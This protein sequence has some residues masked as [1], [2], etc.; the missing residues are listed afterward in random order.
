MFRVAAGIVIGAG[1]V[2]CGTPPPTGRQ[3]PEPIEYRPDQ[4][5]DLYE[6]IDTGAAPVVVVAVH[7]CCGDRRD[8]A[9]LS[10]ALVE[11]G[12]VVANADVHPLAHRG[13]W[14]ETYVDVVCAYAWAVEYAEELGDETKVAIVGWGDGALVTAAVALG[15]SSFA[16]MPD[17][18]VEVSPTV[19]PALVV[20]VG[21]HFGW[22]GEPSPSIVTAATVD[23]F[24]GDPVDQPIA[25]THGNPGWWLA[26]DDVRTT[27]SFALV[28]AENDGVTSEFA[29]NLASRA[30]RADTMLI[31][32]AGHAD[33]VQPR[34]TPGANALDAITQALQLG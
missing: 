34:G 5:L 24:G 30:I 11:R 33:L 20:A 29:A 21:G 32:G 26:S 19:G 12:A 6:P 18:C 4:V 28:G 1:L 31:V 17:D 2:A 16:S 27:V 14:P 8:L 3:P 9:G 13:G 23:W 7:G 25:W 10:R 22:L 15:W